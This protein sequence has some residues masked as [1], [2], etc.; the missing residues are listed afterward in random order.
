MAVN[1]VIYGNDT[2]IDLTSDTAT[3]DK[4]LNGYTFHDASGTLRTGSASAGPTLPIDISSSSNVTGI[5][6]VAN[7]GT[8]NDSGYVRA[9]QKASTTIGTKAT[10]EGYNTTASGNYSH[11]EG[12]GTTASFLAGHAEGTN[13]SASGNSSHAEGY[14]A[15]SS[16]TAS[17]AEG[18]YTSASAD[19][20]HAEGDTTKAKKTAS[21][22][23]GYNTTADGSYSH[24][25]GYF[26]TTS[27]YYAHVEGYFTTAK[28]SCSHVQG[29]YNI[30]DNNNTYAHIVGNG[31]TDNTRSN[32]HTLDWS[33]NAWFAGDVTD[34][35]GN[36]LSNKQN[37]A[38]VLEST[39][40]SGSTSL[41]FTSSAITS[42]AMYDTYADKYGL[43]PTDMVITTGQAVLTFQA[44]SSDVNVRLVIS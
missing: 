31:N 24:A 37:R 18:Y 1:K 42:S 25:E 14:G 33:G 43:T 39:L 10:A 36:V 29:K 35:T 20:A 34:G 17:H 30:Q 5:L 13:T 41:T 40:T 38:I 27:G 6:N 7:G 21:H 23:E 4:V 26:A 19:Y 32:A 12:T 28:G 9:G 11:A 8:G 3:S 2:L 15:A 44:Q 22:A 16:G